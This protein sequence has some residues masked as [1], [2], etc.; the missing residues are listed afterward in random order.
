MVILGNDLIVQGR[1]QPMPS[2]WAAEDPR[3]LLRAVIRVSSLQKS[4]QFYCMHFGFILQAPLDLPGETEQRAVLVASDGALFSL[5]LVEDPAHRPV[6][7]GD[8]FS[9][10]TLVVESTAE[11]IEGLKAAG[12]QGLVD[13]EQAAVIP[14]RSPSVEGGQSTQDVIAEVHDL[15]GYCWRI[16]E[17]KR[18]HVGPDRLCSLA[19]RVTNLD[20]ALMGCSIVL[21]T[22]IQQQYEASQP[23][24]FKTALVGFG[25]EMEAVQLELRQTPTPPLIIRGNGIIRLIVGSSD[26]ELTQAALKEVGEPCQNMEVG[27]PLEVGVYEAAVGTTMPDG[28]EVCF[29]YATATARD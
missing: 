12:Y 6:H 17:A 1:A 16:M 13:L 5:E 21:G 10:F 23:P 20:R 7:P 19:L 29:V 15:D 26:L 11:L 24:E 25:P 4:I 3:A 8:W 9:H 2:G 27:S 28:W 14:V 18:S 22:A